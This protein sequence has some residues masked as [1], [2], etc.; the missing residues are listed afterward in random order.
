MWDTRS[1]MDS[2]EIVAQIHGTL[3]RVDLL[4]VKVLGFVLVPAHRAITT[5]YCRIGGVAG[6]KSKFRIYRLCRC[7]H[8]KNLCV[9][10][11]VLC[12]WHVLKIRSN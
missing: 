8:N 6:R 3:R 12:P 10:W 11:L 7:E 5:E 4:E 1:Q 9:I 2:L